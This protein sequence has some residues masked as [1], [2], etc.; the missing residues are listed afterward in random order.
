MDGCGAVNR[1]SATSVLHRPIQGPHPLRRQPLAVSIGWANGR[2]GL[3][4]IGCRCAAE[5][6]VASSE[7]LDLVLG[8]GDW[9]GRGFGGSASAISF[10]SSP[11]QQK[12]LLSGLSF[13]ARVPLEFSWPHPCV[14]QA[15][16]SCWRLW[17]TTLNCGAVPLDQSRSKP[18]K[19]S[20]GARPPN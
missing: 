18:L 10:S 16:I 5:A 17:M 19:T 4:A 8:L 6:A 9:D 15:P 7:L 14:I 3:G 20:G 12:L 2:A 1:W 13:M 11:R